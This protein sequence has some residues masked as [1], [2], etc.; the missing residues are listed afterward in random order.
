[1]RPGLV[2]SAMF[3]LLLSFAPETEA[4]S[5]IE[6]YRQARFQAE[7]ERLIRSNG[8]QAVARPPAHLPTWADTLAAF[9]DRWKKEPP[10]P[11]P[12]PPSPFDD[13]RWRPLKRL[14]RGWFER[15]FENTA[16]SFLGNTL[17]TRLDTTRTTELRARLEARFGPPTLTM[18]E[19]AEGSSVSSESYIQFEYWIVVNES[20]PLRII[21]VG[22]P[23]DRGLILASDE[24]MRASLFDLRESLERELYNEIVPAAYEDYYFDQETR[25]WYVTGFDGSRFYSRRTTRPN[26]GRGRPFTIDGP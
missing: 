12:P 15:N 7:A 26:L 24:K 9:Y 1:M 13:A 2:S 17:F 4:Q 16:W 20:I 10:P 25:F 5:L 18:V 23:L 3:C 6:Q 14:E 19:A 22:G 21:D 8:L 11:P